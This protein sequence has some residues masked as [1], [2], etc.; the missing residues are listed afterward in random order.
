MNNADDACPPAEFFV[1]SCNGMFRLDQGSIFGLHLEF[2]VKSLLL[3]EEFFT[4]SA[5]ILIIFW[6]IVK[7]LS[8]PADHFFG[9]VSEQ[10][11]RCRIALQNRPFSRVNQKNRIPNACQGFFQK[12]LRLLQL[13]FSPFVFH[14][15][16]GAVSQPINQDCGYS[17][18]QKTF[19]DLRKQDIFPE[20]TGRQQ[21]RNT[22]P[23][24]TGQRKD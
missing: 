23:E 15:K 8:V 2:A 22:N 5:E 19:D 7:K 16:K 1:D 11:F 13:L 24:N 14:F 21:V 20:V 10:T 12:I 4:F 3:F 9:S 17:D 6:L 18:K